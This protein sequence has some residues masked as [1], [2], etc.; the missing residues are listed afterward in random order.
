MHHALLAAR[1]GVLRSHV[2][3]DHERRRHVIQLLGGVGSDAYF[4]GVAGHTVPLTGR[5]NQL[6][7]FA[8]QIGWQAP[9]AW[10][11]P[12]KRRTFGGLVPQRFVRSLGLHRPHN[13]GL[14]GQHALLDYRHALFAASPEQAMRQQLDSLPER[15][16]LS[17]EPFDLVAEFIEDCL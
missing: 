12:T 5:G 6:D 2:L 9:P 8:W 4:L 7:L 13:H 17:G 16:V 15:R 1:T 3:A 10:M 11:M 14:E